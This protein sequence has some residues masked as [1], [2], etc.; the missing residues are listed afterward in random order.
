MKRIAWL[1]LCLAVGALVL[2]GEA[3]SQEGEREGDAPE[4][5]RPAREK[6]LNPEKAAALRKKAAELRELGE[7]GMAKALERRAAMLSGEGGPKDPAGG[8]REIRGRGQRERP[9]RGQGQFSSER[10]E[11]MIEGLEKK[12]AALKEEGKD[13]EAKVAL[14]RAKQLRARTQALKAG[15]ERRQQAAERGQ[16]FRKEYEEMKAR[17]ERTEKELAAIKALLK[18]LAGDENA[19]E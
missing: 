6:K 5:D 13:E 8:E 10:I 12:A 16:A 14:T 3:R 2:T 19:E 7:E 11:R 9:G 18:E 17:L 1:A 4:G 15:G